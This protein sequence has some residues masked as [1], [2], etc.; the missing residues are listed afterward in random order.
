MTTVK[1]TA[2]C[3]CHTGEGVLWH[4]GEQ[5]L[6][7]VDIPN[8]TLF[9][10]DPR[11]D[12]YDAVYERDG[13]IGGF[14]LQRDGTLLLFEEEGRI[15][16]WDPATDETNVVRE[17]VSGEEGSRF[18]DVAAD[19]TGGVF[20][21]TMPRGES[22]G[23]LYRLD[24]DGELS[25]VEEGVGISNGL[26][27]TPD[28]T[29]MYHTETEADVIYRYGFDAETGALGDR[30][31]FVETSDE[32]GSPD[33]LTVDSMGYVWSAR[34]GGECV[35]RYAPT[36]AEVGRVE[37]PARKVSSITIGGPAY[38]RAY[39]TTAL[40]GGTRAEEG[41]GAGSLFEFDPGVRGLPS[42]ESAVGIADESDRNARPNRREAHF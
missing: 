8:G 33:G 28:L 14:T 26:G 38:R 24:P 29:G 30:D 13:A 41:D 20:C 3:S 15:E 1:R 5:R 39:V 17:S 25:V 10:H 23:R 4:P 11:T 6:Y 22:P 19:P 34:W 37:F 36:G 2:A 9:A 18:N 21:G 35:V 32:R 27:F 16:T 12:T 42:F 40:A 31:R 7:W